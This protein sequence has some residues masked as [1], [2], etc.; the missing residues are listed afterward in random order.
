MA[1]IHRRPSHGAVCVIC[2]HSHVDSLP[3]SS[4]PLS[5]PPGSIPGWRRNLQTNSLDGSLPPEYSTMTKMIKLC[6]GC[7]QPRLT[8]FP[9][10]DDGH[11]SPPS[12]PWRRVCDLRPLAR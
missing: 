3:S 1:T 12:V 10:P 6:V 2:A 11:Y 7:A 4:P 8:Q 9:S 5:L